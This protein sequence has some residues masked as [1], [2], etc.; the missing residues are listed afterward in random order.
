MGKIA[1]TPVV[2]NDEIVIRPIMTLSLTYDH[3]VVDG[4][5][6]AQFLKRIKELLQAPALLL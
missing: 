5:P 3:R 2:V 1:K 6:A 4:A